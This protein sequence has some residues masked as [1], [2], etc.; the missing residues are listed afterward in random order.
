MIYLREDL[1]ADVEMLCAGSTGEMEWLVLNSKRRRLVF[2]TVYRSPTCSNHSFNIALGQISQTL[3]KLNRPQPSIFVTGDFNFPM[4]NWS[5]EGV[6]EGTRDSRTQAEKFINFMSDNMLIQYVEEPTRGNNILDLVLTNDHQMIIG[7]SVDDTIMSDHR[8]LTTTVNMPSCAETGPALETIREGLGSLNFFHEDVKWDL[9]N[10]AFADVDWSTELADRSIDE[11]HEHISTK[12]REV[13]W[14]HFP[15][16]RGMSKKKSNIPKD[17]SVLMRKRRKVNQKMKDARDFPTKRKLSEQLM[18]IEMELAESHSREQTREENRAIRAIAANPKFFY[19][20]AQSKSRIRSQVGPLKS[21]DEWC[22]D[23]VEMANLLATQYSGAFSTPKYTREENETLIQLAEST[24]GCLTDITVTEWDVTEAIKS[25]NS[26]SAAGP[27]EVPA[28]LL[29]RCAES[30]A[31]PLV[32]LWRRSLEIS[33]IPSSCKMGV[34]TPIHKGGARGEPKNYRPVTL[35]SHLI[36]TFERVIIK[37]LVGFMEQEMLYNTGQHGFRKGRS[38]LS[39]LL[40]HQMRILKALEDNSSMDVIYLDFAKAFDKVDHGVLL[41]KVQ[42]MGVGGKLLKWIWEFLTHRKQAV[43]VNGARSRV[44]D[45]V[46][47]VPQGTVLGPILFLIHV[48]DIDAEVEHA[49]V[50]SFADDTRLSAAVGTEE[51][52]RRLQDDLEKV[53]KWAEVNNM[54]F[55]NSKFVYMRYGGTAH[56]GTGYT[57][58]DGSQIGRSHTTRDLGVLM[59]DTG[60]FPEHIS[61]MLEKAKR[62]VGWI[63]RVFS[64]RDLKTMLTLFRALVLPVVEYC[65]QL[66]SPCTIGVIRQME[67]IQRSF[68]CRIDG[69]RD[70]NYWERLRKL[71]LYS[72]ERRRERY[73]IIYTWKVVNSLVPNI[74]EGEDRIRTHVHI[75]RGK[76]CLILRRSGRTLQSVQTMREHS[77]AVLGP[78]LYNELGPELR[79]YGGKL[80]GFKSRLDRFLSSVP[81]R[82][83][84]PKYVQSAAGNSLLDQ[85]A[86]QRAERAH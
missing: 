43:V 35:T 68:T 16:R 29:K 34:I 75:R 40:Q 53:Y 66:W 79:E 15:V 52:A 26:N 77:L 71:G 31:K 22:G 81:D 10:Q 32:M 1:A 49:Q 37:K 39:Q 57:D 19:T 72:L 61:E 70:V 47:G 12:I 86:Q 56:P 73:A 11:M 54:T 65:S 7:N 50:A 82:P 25:I 76:L 84:M 8:M 3:E 46:S 48:T 74:S 58:Q 42:G 4:V 59:S 44:S 2:V 78:R 55:N 5:T 38:C 51:D 24:E 63:L 64:A 85:L 14:E 13:S 83:A 80:E 30:L 9:V 62:T 18:K 23:S 33:R 69:M 20:Y 27:D 60:R 41:R 6:A 28:I 36:K 67:A 17:R 45:V 21:G